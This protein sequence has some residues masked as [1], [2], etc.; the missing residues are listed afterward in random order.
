MAKR[1]KTYTLLFVSDT[2]H[3][4]AILLDADDNDDARR[5]TKIL[6]DEHNWQPGDTVPLSYFLAGGDILDLKDAFVWHILTD[7]QVATIMA[8]GTGIAQG[9]IPAP[10]APAAPAAPAAATADPAP[11]A[12]TTTTPTTSDDP[13]RAVGAG[14]SS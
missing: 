10:S 6:T 9:T 8:A 13:V 4:A 11:A 5:K 1:P 3:S 7:P 12:T 14:P 2:T